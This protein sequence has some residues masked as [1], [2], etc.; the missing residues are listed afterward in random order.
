MKLTALSLMLL[1]PLA[2]FADSPDLQTPSPVIYLADNLDE[3]D[4]L[5]Y[6]LD[7]VGRGLSDRAHIH[8]C[9]PR[10][11]DVQFEFLEHS[12]QIKSATFDDLCL[13]IAGE[14][15]ALTA[16]TDAPSQSFTYDP[17]EGTLEPSV[18]PNTCLVSS[19][20]S[21]RAGPF[22]ARNLF[23]SDC[24]A[25]PDALRRWVILP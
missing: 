9:K 13:D 16:C 2:A 25:T 3:P 24:D 4:R 23:L 10:G 18:R 14:A 21:R 17:E 19:A 1:T 11:G 7:T 5:G 6:C 8:S 20:S 22:M 15:F 12:G